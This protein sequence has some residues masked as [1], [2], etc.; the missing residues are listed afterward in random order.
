MDVYARIFLDRPLA[1]ASPLSILH[2]KV[3]VNAASGAD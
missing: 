3:L 2:L 1:S